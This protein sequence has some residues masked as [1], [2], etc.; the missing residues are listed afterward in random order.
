MVLDTYLVMDIPVSFFLFLGLKLA[1]IAD[2][3]GGQ[4]DG[5][6]Y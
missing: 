5:D 1:C 3:L 4:I 2:Q 6:P